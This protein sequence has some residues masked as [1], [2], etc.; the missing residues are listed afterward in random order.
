MNKCHILFLL[1][2]LP[3]CSNRAIYENMQIQQ[4]NDCRKEAPQD[5]AACIKRTDMLYEE[6]LRERNA[7]LT[8]RTK[9]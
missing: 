7:V 6:Y 3:A 5:Y 2:G 8:E 9:G 1:L 4:R